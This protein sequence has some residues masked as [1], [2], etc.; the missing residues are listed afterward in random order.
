MLLVGR[1]PAHAVSAEDPV[2]RRGR[3]RQLV[4][5][6]QVVGDLARA[7]VVML[8]KVQNLADDFLRRRLRRAVRR[9]R[10]I[11]QSGHAVLAY[12]RFHL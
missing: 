11:A 9:P 10:P 5:A 3:H 7:E 8:P 12:R 2:H 6:L 4:K 1:Q